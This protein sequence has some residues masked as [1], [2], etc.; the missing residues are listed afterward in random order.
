MTHLDGE[1][2]DN[3]TSVVTGDAVVL[4]LRPAGFA[5]R[6]VALA[7]DVLIQLP[8]LYLVTWLATRIGAD[9]DIAVMA[10]VSLGASV[11]IIV[12]YPTAFETLTRGRS[13]GKLVMGVRV[14][15]SDGSPEQF[16]QA[17]ARGLCAAV[18]IWL[19]S[20][21]IALLTSMIH[22]DGKRVGDFVAG[23]LVVEERVGRKP[24]ADIAM[25]AELAEWAATA[26]MS[27]LTPDAVV[28]ARQYVLR[29]SELTEQARGEMGN[30]ITGLVSA[31]V[32]PPPPEGTPPVHY[33][34]AVL[35]ERRRRETDKLAR[36]QAQHDSL[37]S[38]QE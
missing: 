35:A 32:S 20:G 27:A 38:R 22:R 30:Q 13:L 1:P 21:V 25:P 23:T 15:G 26:E 24:E 31:A 37:H 36:R 18:E 29:Y 28:M 5:T 6:M 34:A 2:Y 9:L 7:F 8:L 11:L 12:G 14:V 4:E 16:R 19:A 10:A 17:L 3:Q 33:L